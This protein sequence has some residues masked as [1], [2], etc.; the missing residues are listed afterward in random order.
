MTN[1]PSSPVVPAHATQHYGSDPALARSR[2]AT[3]FVTNR[4][5]QPPA[6]RAVRPEEDASP[7][8][9]IARSAFEAAPTSRAPLAAETSGVG[10]AATAPMDLAEAQRGAATV[11]DPRPNAFTVHPSPPSPPSQA[12]AA[13]VDLLATLRAEDERARLAPPG[14]PITAPPPATRPSAPPQAMHVPAPMAALAA[15]ALAAAS[16]TPSAPAPAPADAKK[17][18]LDPRYRLLPLAIF[19]AC[20]LLGVFETAIALLVR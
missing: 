19:G 9:V 7:T 20:A 10:Q 1:R 17:P 13:N 11:F 4:P 14:R 5:P 16:A 18:I 8:T 3:V 15:P 2:E 12:P 6:S